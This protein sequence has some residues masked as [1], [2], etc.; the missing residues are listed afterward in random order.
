MPA[1][2]NAT[3]K[4]RS[5]RRAVWTLLA[6]SVGW[7]VFVLTVGAALPRW[8]MDDGVAAQPTELQPFARHAKHG[9][10]ALW[11][12]PLERHGVVRMVRVVS[13]ERDADRPSRCGGYGARVKAY[14]YFGVP[15]SEARTTCDSGAVEY[16]VLRGRGQGPT[17]A[18]PTPAP[19]VMPAGARGTRA[20]D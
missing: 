11:N 2:P 12:G 13:V 15:Y 10:A 6:I 20:G 1:A 4:T 9:A 17:V 5:R 7:K 8:F 19:T 3:P 18:L 16:R 14:T